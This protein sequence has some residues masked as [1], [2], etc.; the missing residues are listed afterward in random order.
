MI[1]YQNMTPSQTSEDRIVS[2]V[3]TGIDTTATKLVCVTNGNLLRYKTDT[4]ANFESRIVSV[5][6]TGIDTTATKVLVITDGNLLQTNSH[7]S[8]WILML[9]HVGGSRVVLYNYVLEQLKHV[10]EA[11]Y[12]IFAGVDPAPEAYED[13][14]EQEEEE[15]GE[16]EEGEEEDAFS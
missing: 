11:H 7:R 6:N 14:D 12:V 13:A 15:E 16:E 4:N 1:T 10:T 5:A 8:M 9:F 3:N 2:V